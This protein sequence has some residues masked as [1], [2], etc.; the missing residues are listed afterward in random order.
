MEE[1][2]TIE[3]QD[4][5]KVDIRVGRIISV[6]IFP[7]AKKPAL[8]LK[9]DFGHEIGIKKSSAQITEN[10]NSSNLLNKQ[11]IAVVNFRPRQIGPF[12]SE[13]LTLGVSDKQGNI[14]LLSPD[15]NVDEGE[16]LH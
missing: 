13:V 4:F 14:I 3:I 6:E 15:K 16:K 2:S 7:Q 10:Y 1:N 8:K 5:L 9:I 12:I 11:I